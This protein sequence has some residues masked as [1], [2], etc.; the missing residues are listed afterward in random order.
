MVYRRM[1]S[2]QERH[3]SL[4]RLLQQNQNQSKRTVWKSQRSFRWQIQWYGWYA[5]KESLRSAVDY[6]YYIFKIKILQVECI[7][8]LPGGFFYKDRS[9]P[10]TSAINMNTNDI[11]KIWIICFITHLLFP[12]LITQYI[13]EYFKNGTPEK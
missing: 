12:S 6:N 7:L 1:E 8:I 9:I 13:S 2:Q 4:Q 11:I 5:G 10:C 3:N